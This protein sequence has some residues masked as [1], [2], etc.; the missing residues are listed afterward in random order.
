MVAREDQT[1]KKKG[2]SWRI[3]GNQGRLSR[4][5]TS[6]GLCSHLQQQQVKH[7]RSSDGTL[8]KGDPFESSSPSHPRLLRPCG[9]S[10]SHRRRQRPGGA[11]RS[12]PLPLRESSISRLRGSADRCETD[13]SV[14][15]VCQ[16]NGSCWG[17]GQKKKAVIAS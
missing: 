2:F 17:T 14:G 7:E 16:Q 10:W 12:T 1:Q 15:P 6:G 13:G 8:A 11:I 4:L 9:A 5:L 3:F